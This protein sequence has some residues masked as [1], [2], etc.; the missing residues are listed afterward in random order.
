M[1]RE[2]A[3]AQSPFSIL[4]YLRNQTTARLYQQHTARIEANSFRS[5]IVRMTPTNYITDPAVH[6][7]RADSLIYGYAIEVRREIIQASE[8]I[9]GP[10][11]FQLCWDRVLTE[12]EREDAGGDIDACYKTYLGHPG[13]LLVKLRQCSVEKAIIEVAYRLS[14]LTP[15][16]Y[17]WLLSEIAEDA[18]L[19]DTP[20]WD[21]E[22]GR[23]V[24]D[25]HQIR[26][27]R[28]NAK[29]VV[30]ILDDF[31]EL[32]WPRSIIDPFQNHEDPQTVHQ[33]VSSLNTNL[34][35][36]RFYVRDGRVCWESSKS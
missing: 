31:E 36:L 22:S 1:C 12:A 24:F 27:F 33:S 9:R 29:N 30:K 4:D 32:N 5:F 21:R 35:H 10:R 16:S 17:E 28:S 7:F 25:G 13:N 26:K 15:Q 14:F 18:P 23:L 2:L 20:V 8:R 6:G 11:G 34:E 3:V 19:T